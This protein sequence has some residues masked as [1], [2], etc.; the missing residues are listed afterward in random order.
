[1]PKCNCR[2]EI[3]RPPVRFEIAFGHFEA[4]ARWIGVAF[5]TIVDRYR[6]TGERRR[7]CRYR[8]AQVGSEG[9]NPTLARHIITNYGDS[10][11]WLVHLDCFRLVAALGRHFLVVQHQLDM[12][13]DSGYCPVNQFRGSDRVDFAGRF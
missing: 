7:K 2:P 1:M 6:K 12:L 3:G 9:C 13:C 8:L 10:I 5:L 4:N 11:D